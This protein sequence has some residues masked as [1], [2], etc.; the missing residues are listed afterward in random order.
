MMR[1]CAILLC[2]SFLLATGCAVLRQSQRTDSRAEPCALTES[3]HQ[4]ARA[5]AHYGQGLIC[6]A[7]AGRGSSNALAHFKLAA[8]L[9]ADNHDLYAKIAV[10]ELQRGQADHAL[11]ALNQSVLNA[12]DSFQRRVDLAATYQSLG[13]TNE[14]IAAYGE[15]LRIDPGKTPVYATIAGLLFRQNRDIAA[16]DVL[17]LGVRKSSNPDALQEY[18]LGQAKRFIWHNDMLRAVP[19]FERLA[20]WDHDD[21]PQS[22]R[23]LAAIH[24]ASGDQKRAIRFLKLATRHANASLEAFID[25]ADLYRRVKPNRALPLLMKA[26]KRFPEDPRLSF[27]LGHLHLL[28][29]NQD[30][31]LFYLSEATEHESAPA[32][33][34]LELA[35]IHSR[36]SPEKA[37][38]ALRSGK[39]RF[40]RDPTITFA[41]ACGLNDA[42]RY[43]EA[44]ILFEDARD[45]VRERERRSTQQPV[46]SQA[47]YLRYGEACERSGQILKAEAVF[48]ECILV[49]TESHAAMNYLAYMWAQNDLKLDQA[50]EHIDRALELVPDSGAYI[51]TRGWIYYKQKKYDQALKE[52]LRANEIIRNDPEITGHIT[53]IMEAMKAGNR[54][55]GQD[56]IY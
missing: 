2:C 47:F 29:G 4:F 55:N 8:E 16:L 17:D 35:D 38:A 32:K 12:P 9:D 10:G 45:S 49:Y 50:L 33:A 53:E 13:R 5:L 26:R 27:A 31:A 43:Q 28:H 22:Y 41:L 1:A 30:S 51:D 11:Q 40:P 37:L 15:A 18:C 42:G 56:G 6:E 39:E 23:A 34:F 14:A 54:G 21:A 44:I 48:E 3:E 7:E 19:C 36:T 20:R 46:L 25:L 24:D 52:V